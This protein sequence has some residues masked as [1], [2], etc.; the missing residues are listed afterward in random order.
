MN[1]I[2][3][4]FIDSYEGRNIND[5]SNN[6]LSHLIAWISQLEPLSVKLGEIQVPDAQ[7]K[8]KIEEK[9]RK[10]ISE[11]QQLN[12]KITTSAEYKRYKC[13]PYI[14][15]TF[16]TEWE[17]I[18]NSREENKEI[19]PIEPIGPEKIEQDTKEI[20]G[21]F[22]DIS[23][24]GYSYKN[25]PWGR[26]HYVEFRKRYQIKKTIVQERTS[27]P[28]NDGTVKFGPWNEISSKEEEINVFCYEKR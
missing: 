20:I 17:E 9:E 18:E 16:Y 24:G 8:E 5:K 6:E 22:I 4:I 1:N 10:I 3:Q 19:L 12:I 2:P 23:T 25:T 28:L 7:I 27:Q 14:G 15:D 13:I 21:P 11:T 26:R